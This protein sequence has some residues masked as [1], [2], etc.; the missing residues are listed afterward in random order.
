MSRPATLHPLTCCLLIFAVALYL[1]L[2]PLAG[3]LALLV[4]MFGWRPGRREL[5]QALRRMRWLLLAML[6]LAAWT[7]PGAPLFSSRFAP[8]IPGLFAGAHQALA[9]LL[10]ALLARGVWLW[11]GTPGLLAASWP[12]DALFARAGMPRGRLAL[13]L[14]LTVQYA[15]HLLEQPEK[16][17]LTQLLPYLQAPQFAQ[18]RPDKVQLPLYPWSKWDGALL[19][20]LLLAVVMRMVA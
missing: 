16:P 18:A 14:A 19:V 5:V 20:C 12:L 13:R 1:M 6:L 15:N 8:S 10:L 2:L 4:L 17:R 11:L 3:Y 7:L 9:V